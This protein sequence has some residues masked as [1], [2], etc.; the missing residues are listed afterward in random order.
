MLGF[1]IE[2]LVFVNVRS[3]C[4]FDTLTLLMLFFCG[5]SFGTMLLQFSFINQDQIMLPS[6]YMFD[7]HVDDFPSK[8][9]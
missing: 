4:C 5:F 2:M 6:I 3:W 7:D 8:T 9:T 1:K